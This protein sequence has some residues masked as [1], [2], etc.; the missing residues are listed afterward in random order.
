MA[1]GSKLAEIIKEKG[2]TQK[3]VA[4]KA[5]IK[6][7]T[8]NKIITR[9]SARADVQLFLK[10]CKVLE[11]PVSIFAEDALEE[12]YQ[13]HPNIEKLESLSEYRLTEI[14]LGERLKTARIRR[15]AKTKDMAELLGISERAY[16]N[17]ENSQRDI[18]TQALQKI[19][20]YLKIS[21]EYLLGISDSMDIKYCQNNNDMNLSYRKKRIVELFDELTPQQQ[22]NI[23]GRAE[24]LAEQNDEAY[25]QE[26]NA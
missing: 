23:I 15:N 24:L 16:R 3:E 2:L 19:C 13:D 22:D 8:L 18:G 12:F 17:Y 25:K 7:Q 9:D 1:V 26:E 14:K 20:N 21:S 4:D 5:G 6:P 10:I 11:V